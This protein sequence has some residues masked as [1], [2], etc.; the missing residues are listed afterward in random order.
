VSCAQNNE[1]PLY[2]ECKIFIQSARQ[3][4]FK[5]YFAQKRRRRLSSPFV[6]QLSAADTNDTF[7]FCE[8]TLPGLLFSKTI[9]ASLFWIK[10]SLVGTGK[11]R[12]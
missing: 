3:E 5:I 12:N 4:V 2:G 1:F 10:V 6:F 11:W 8:P 7:L 9:S